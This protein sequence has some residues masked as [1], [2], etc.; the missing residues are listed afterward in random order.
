ML[1]KNLISHKF[2]FRCDPCGPTIAIIEDNGTKCETMFP[3][4]YLFLKQCLNWN[5][6]VKRCSEMKMKLALP[7]NIAENQ[8]FLAN[9][10]S[11]PF[12]IAVT[13]GPEDGSWIDDEGQNVTFT[14][15]A[16]GFPK[17]YPGYETKKTAA[18]VMDNGLWETAPREWVGDWIDTLCV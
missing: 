13:E 15:W 17:P 12:W 2:I 14:N 6:A 3:G 11:T 18:I 9:A 8:D 5:R 7:R 16:P 10:L 4:K 1:L